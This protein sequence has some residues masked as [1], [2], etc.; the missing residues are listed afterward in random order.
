MKLHFD[1]I[2]Y[3]SNAIQERAKSMTTWGH[4]T[5]VDI[6]SFAP[7]TTL[8]VANEFMYVRGGTLYLPSMAIRTDTMFPR[9]IILVNSS[10][11]QN[12]PRWVSL[13]L[14]HHELG[15]LTPGALALEPCSIE[16]E[17]YCDRYADS[18][19]DGKLHLAFLWFN[20]HYPGVIQ[21]ERIEASLPKGTRKS[22]SWRIAKV[23][24]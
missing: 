5:P 19:T 6:E 17:L 9:P 12:V 4:T 7:N 11:V 3:T 22:L 15:H 20:E 18:V 16:Q 13:I 8:L 10:W 23:L 14:V 24:I 1:L 21:Q 2:K